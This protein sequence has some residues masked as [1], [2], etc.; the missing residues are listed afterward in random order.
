MTTTTRTAAP[1]L[2]TATKISLGLGVEVCKVRSSDGNRWYS[3]TRMGTFKKDGGT[4]I[5]WQCSCPAHAFTR[6]TAG[7]T[8]KHPC[9][10]L[11][12][13]WANKVPADS[14]I[15]SEGFATLD[16]AK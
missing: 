1:A 4:G 3:V 13:L 10:H 12:A 15:R 2:A 9:K 16:W 8:Q 14:L 7:K 6:P 11:R 5:E